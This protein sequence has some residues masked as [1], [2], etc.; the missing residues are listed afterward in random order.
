MTL[1]HV[2]GSSKNA[3]DEKLRENMKKFV[4]THGWYTMSRENIYGIL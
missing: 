4:D 1:A 2:N 3:A